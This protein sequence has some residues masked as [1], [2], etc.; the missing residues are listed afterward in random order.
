MY[1]D[2]DPLVEQPSAPVMTSYSIGRSA[3]RFF[4]IAGASFTISV[5][6]Q[7]VPSGLSWSL[8]GVGVVAWLSSV[9]A[10][11]LKKGDD[12]WVMVG[13][14][15]FGIFGALVGF[16]ELLSKVSWSQATL[17]IVVVALVLALF[18]AIERLISSKGKAQEVDY[19]AY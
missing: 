8:L 11:I 12:S 13:V 6:A 16:G 4:A 19:D 10:A 5:V 1:S 15:A 18:V 9:G 3:L 7:S 2:V 17:P 14:T